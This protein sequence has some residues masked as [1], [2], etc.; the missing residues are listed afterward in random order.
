MA[1]FS[2]ETPEGSAYDLSVEVGAGRAQEPAPARKR[3]PRWTPKERL[4]VEEY[5]IHG[6]AARAARRA[7]Y[8]EKSARFIGRDLL[9]KTHIREAI[10]AHRQEVASRFAVTAERV[11]EELS[12]VA[13]ADPIQLLDEHGNYLPLDR[14]PEEIR[15][16][17]ASLDVDELTEDRG[18]TRQL[19]LALVGPDGTP[20]RVRVQTK[21]IRLWSKL[22]ALRL[23]GQ[24]LGI[25]GSDHATLELGPRLE[26]AL[27]RS[28]ALRSEGTA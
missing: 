10:E 6:N 15:R 26:A 18:A 1:N 22:E 17:I 12:R 2:A 11:I 4:F 14:M 9:T 24:K 8:A 3:A 19:S 27:R 16:A 13:Y 23:L 25:F 5:L 21:R 28:G 20:I 7:G